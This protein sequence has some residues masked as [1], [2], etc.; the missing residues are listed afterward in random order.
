V[1]DFAGCVPFPTRRSPR[2]MQTNLDG[3]LAYS[4]VG[5]NHSFSS[6]MEREKPMQRSEVPALPEKVPAGERN[7]LEVIRFRSGD[8]RRQA[9][10]VLLD[11]GM[12]NFTSYSEEEWLVR[13]PVARKLR[14]LGVPFEWL[15]EHA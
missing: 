12:L 3:K 1:I 9:I 13:T 14:D 5:M 10:G 2:G 8:A 4:K 7:R 11:Y 6:S 15:T